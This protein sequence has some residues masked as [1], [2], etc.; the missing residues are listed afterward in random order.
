LTIGAD[1][2]QRAIPGPDADIEQAVRD[3]A[4]EKGYG[5]RAEPLG[6]LDAQTDPVEDV[7][8]W[9]VNDLLKHIRDASKAARIG[10]V[11][12]DARRSENAKP[13]PF[14]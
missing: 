2:Y 10:A 11:V 8:S 12:A 6:L 5:A 3:A 7:V 1:E 9:L 4:Q 13:S 14:D